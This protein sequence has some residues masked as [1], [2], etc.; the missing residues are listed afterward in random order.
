M[1]HCIALTLT[2]SY[3]LVPDCPMG[4]VTRERLDLEGE[5]PSSDTFLPPTQ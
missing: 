1:G 3:G 2:C 4:H 5:D